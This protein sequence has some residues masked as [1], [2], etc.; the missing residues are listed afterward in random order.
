[1]FSNHSVTL[2]MTLAG[3]LAV[4][5]F[6]IVAMGYLAFETASMTERA[7]LEHGRAIG[8][9][10]AETVKRRLEVALTR[11]EDLA[12]TFQ[13]LAER[14]DTDREALDG[15]LRN[16]MLANPELAGAW[17]GFEPG[18]LDERDAEL[19]AAGAPNDGRYDTYFYDF[20]DSE[21]LTQY[22]LPSLDADDETSSYYKV[23]LTSGKAFL[24]EPTVYDIQG[25]AA[26]MTS[27]CH[28]IRLNGRVVGV[29]GVD[30]LLN[31]IWS[32][33]KEVRPFGTGSVHV[34]S[35]GGKWVGYPESDAWGKDASETMPGLKGMESWIGDAK[36]TTIADV[37][38]G[39][40]AELVRL[41]LPFSLRG[42]DSSWA[43]IVTLPVKEM[44]ADA[45][46]QQ[47][48]TWIVGVVLLAVLVVSLAVIGRF[49]VSRPV[50]RVIETIGRI[51]GGDYDS[52]IPDLRR[53]DEIG[54]IARALSGFR[55]N[56]KRV[57]ELER[58]QQAS[59]QRAR[60]ER[61]RALRELADTFESSIG[62]TVSAVGG[63]AR[64]MAGTSKG[65]SNIADGA[66]GQ[67][68][69][70]AEAAEQASA[71][72][73]TVAAASE[74]LAASI[75]EIGGQVHRASGVSSQAVEQAEDA[76]H[77]VQGLAA[78][79]ERIGE[80]V[81]LITDIADQ[82][83]LLALN[84]TI[85]A[86]RAGEAGKGFAVVAS[87]VKNLANQT[88]KATEEI[89][90]QINSIQAET[91]NS[92]AVIGE[93]G[94]TIATINDIAAS[95]AAAVEEQ[96]AATQEISRSVQEASSGTTMVTSNIVRVRESTEETGRSAVTVQ[97]A[98][99]GLAEQ[100]SRLNQQ[101]ADFL[102]KI[103]S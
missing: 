9:T 16:T 95:I 61:V 33:L 20:K 30:I 69:A 17:A 55:D 74:Q 90:Q 39:S 79:A 56:L 27:L 91:K 78:A 85:E 82:T 94:T 8:R 88:A 63:A 31:D 53:G 60:D 22:H 101:V 86:A 67:A 49:V 64:E 5:A 43:V 13:A 23:P 66:V 98:A 26:F 14:G 38:P 51:D 54:R 40:G 71:N 84:A 73:S 65:M 93:I 21:G 50:A 92:V 2:K 34:V 46:W 96:N 52:E 99:N 29:A 42:L 47:T 12:A 35:G 3:A 36:E 97:E 76:N 19:A 70:V 24:T 102:S 44:L 45:S 89:G 10:E 57:R 81:T 62:E 59:E 72:V 37:D 83:N 25:K 75:G 15:I 100:A 7:A 6:M 68:I 41:V 32:D 77:R 28:P 58:E 1:M 80:V 18:A 103:R 48:L 87:E 4:T 11:A